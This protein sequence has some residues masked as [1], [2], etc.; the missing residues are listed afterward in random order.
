MKRLRC[1]YVDVPF[2]NESG[3]DKNRSRFLWQA[4]RA[5]FDTDLVLVQREAANAG[6]PAFSRF[7][8]AL[9][10]TPVR[11]PWHHSDSVFGFDQT[12]LAAFDAVL[13]RNRFDVVVGRFHSPWNL[14]RRAAAQPAGPAV[15]MD[16][17]MVSSRLVALTWQQQPSFKN[18]WFLFEKLK[19][20]RLERQIAR[21]PFLVLFSNPEEL[22]SFDRRCH[23][24]GS[25]STLATLPN[26]MP[27]LPPVAEV[28]LQPVILFF[29]SMNSSANTDG[30]TFL[31]EQL[32]PRLDGDLRRAGVKIH[33]VGRNP[34]GWF[35]DR[36]RAA[37]TDR[38]VLVGGVDSM[39]RAIAESRF[40]LLPLRV[41]SG[42]RTRILEAAAQARAVVTTPIG[43]EGIE[44]GDAALVHA[45]P[46]KLAEAVRRLV[47]DSAAAAQLGARLRERCLERYAADRVA[48]ELV[49][50]IGAFTANRRART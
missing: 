48:A 46:D 13:E 11:G 40:V 20:E 32:L 36:I 43:A 7:P 24:H 19:L 39:E 15:V 21:Q 31:V 45:E 42:T 26:V 10:L 33:V 18:R 2:E 4:L 44:V 38:I 41:A 28:A 30:F 47:F 1:L 6:R 8:P 35:A 5:A 3:G 14:L 17:D 9:T 37:G 27:T 34:P 50:E 22:K 25:R 23:S 49:R 12:A 16:L 29:G